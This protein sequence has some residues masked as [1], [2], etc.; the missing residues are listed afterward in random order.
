ML[1][2]WPWG[3][4]QIET[5]QISFQ[6]TLKCEASKIKI[7]RWGSTRWSFKMTKTTS[8]MEIPTNLQEN[9]KGYFKWC[10][11]TL[12]FFGSNVQTFLSRWQNPRAWPPQDSG[13]LG[14]GKFQK[15]H[16]QLTNDC[17]S[18]HIWL[19]KP[20]WRSEDGLKCLQE[21]VGCC[22]LE[23]LAAVGEHSIF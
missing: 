14:V 7:C 17:W 22:V 20:Q 15:Y 8:V 13:G 12:H 9:K 1:V 6:S 18:T 3:M 10:L 4:F 21:K 2:K 5:D 19:W 11:V 23:T 16:S